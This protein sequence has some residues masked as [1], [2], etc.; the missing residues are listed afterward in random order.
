MKGLLTAT[1]ALCGLVSFSAG[2][3]A[4][5]RIL[6]PQSAPKATRIAA[7][8]F[9]RYWYGICGKELAVDERDDGGSSYVKIG[10]PEADMSFDSKFDTYYVR[11]VADGGRTN[12]VIAGGN[13]RSTI[14]AVYDFLERRCGCRWFWDGDVVPKASSI[15]IGGLDVRESSRF[16]F[17]ATH[18]F[19]HRGLTRFQATHWGLDDWKREIDFCLKSRLNFFMLQIGLDDV[20]QRAFPD[21]V[22][23]PDP[24]VTQPPE[25]KGRPG[26][27]NHSPH[28]DLAYRGRLRKAIMDYAYDRGMMHPA[29]FG[30]LTHWFSRTPQDFLDKM[31]PPFLP[32][33]SN[34]YKEPSGLIWDIRQPKWF[35]M[36][37]RITEA[38]I[39]SWCKPDL[40][41]TPG[42]DERTMYRDREL[43]LR[44]KA[45]VV[46]RYLDSARRRYPQSRLLIEGWDLHIA[47]EPSEV[48]EFIP[49]LDPKTTVIW[50]YEADASR[51]LQLKNRP[52][53]NNFTEWGVVGR[54]PYVFGMLMALER[55]CDIRLDYDTVTMR[56]R[57]IRDDP[58][59]VG[60]ILW[61]ETSHSD[62]F[63]WRYFTSNCWRLSD[64]SVPEILAGFCRDRYGRAAAA[65]ESVW[66]RVLPI[67]MLANWRSVY[68]IDVTTASGLRGRWNDAEALD[69]F[70]FPPCLRRAP[71]IFRDI[72]QLPRHDAF[73]ARDAIDLART[74]G[75]RLIIASGS[76][77]AKRCRHLGENGCKVE[78]IERYA[79]AYVAAGEAMARVLALHGDYSLV[80]S[81]DRLSTIHPVPNP[82]F[83]HVLFEN[84]ANSY[85]R[86]HQ[87]EFAAHWYVD[88]MRDITADIL[89]AVR[90]G[91]VEKLPQSKRDRE[92]EM[93]ALPHPIRSQA[94]DLPRTDDS[95]RK[96]MSDFADAADV[97]TARRPAPEGFDEGIYRSSR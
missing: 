24:S 47:W 14:Y 68:S 90:R 78:D 9:G 79:A 20:F 67:S 34:S 53:G 31:K 49:L 54:F 91:A 42:F 64:A 40:L 5:P 62:P 88:E 19:A 15:D 50:D 73:A 81:L 70:V 38:Q 94:L 76:E 30:T 66:R 41:F 44:F 18:Y 63:A 95:Y 37:W 65:F 22:S 61:P 2:A 69:R 3:P 58:F 13:A 27:D 21:V 56:Q 10:I 89:A 33:A 80:E 29:E 16:E 55:G 57:V 52:A 93:L 87:A 23:Y 12:L 4:V 11:S 77:M 32:Q 60:Y 72:A 6:L 82:D 25:W 17:R 51:K 71:G 35:D 8:E 86:S 36:Y 83:E 7:E 45:D 96:A 85:C 74:V 75:D 46:K 84:A 48:R 39:S 92:V 28:W 1:F 59:C 43:N 26:Y 97:L